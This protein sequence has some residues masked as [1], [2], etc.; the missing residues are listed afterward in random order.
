LKVINFICI[1]STNQ[2]INQSTNQQFNNLT[3]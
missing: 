3:I 2:P 1:F